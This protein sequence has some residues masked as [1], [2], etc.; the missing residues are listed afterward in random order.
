MAKQTAG[1]RWTSFIPNIDPRPHED[2]HVAEQRSTLLEARMVYGCFV[3]HE[4]VVQRRGIF[5]CGA[6][7]ATSFAAWPAFTHWSTS[8]ARNFHSRPSLCESIFL[9][10]IHL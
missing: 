10:S 2:T 3:G 6:L 5:R 1:G 4:L 8:E 7:V 9:R